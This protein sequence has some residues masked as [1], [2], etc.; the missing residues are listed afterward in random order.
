MQSIRSV[1]FTAAAIAITV[2]AFVLTASLALALAGIAAVV[3]IG[4]A[5]AARF[6]A[7]PM[8]ARTRAAAG[9]QRE[10]RI[11]NDGRGTIIDL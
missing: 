9:Q 7:K 10:M 5:I 2:A 6:N 4:S 8:P 1:L 11:W 3:A